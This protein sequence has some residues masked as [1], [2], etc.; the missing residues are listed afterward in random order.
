MPIEPL[1]METEDLPLKVCL[2]YRN[3]ASLSEIERKLGF[4]HPTQVKRK[5]LEGLNILLELW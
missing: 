3:R 5:L 4:N 2:L 1:E